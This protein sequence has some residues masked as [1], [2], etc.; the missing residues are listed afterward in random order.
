[1][2]EAYDSRGVL[3]FGNGGETRWMTYAEL[4]LARGIDAASA[5]RLALRRRWRRQAGNDGTARV[6]VPLDEARPRTSKQAAA[7]EAARLISSLEAALA[8]LREQLERERK[9]ADAATE[10]AE[11]GT[12]R[13]AEA[14]ARVAR[15]RSSLDTAALVRDSLER[16]LSAEERARQGAE[17][18][19]IAEQAL[20]AEAEAEALRLTEQLERNAGW[21]ARLWSALRGT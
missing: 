7:E 13:L 8:T 12:H 18:A 1:M 9:R 21:M 17:E 6:E 19:V 20:R 10:A 4:G 5:K 3:P 15:L 16:A 11:Q 14:E 2:P